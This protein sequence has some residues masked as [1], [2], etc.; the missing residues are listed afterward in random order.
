MDDPPAINDLMQV[1]SDLVHTSSKFVTQ[2]R[3]D[4]IV[5]YSEPYIL[6][7]QL[8]ECNGIFC[9]EVVDLFSYSITDGEIQC[10]SEEGAIHLRFHI[11]LIILH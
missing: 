7:I 2:V 6:S 3:H 8:M 1:L 9:L 11:S 10:T 4:L 5:I